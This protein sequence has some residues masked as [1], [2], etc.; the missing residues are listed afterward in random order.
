MPNKISSSASETAAAPIT[1]ATVLYGLI[2]HPAHHSLSPLIHNRGFLERQISARYLA[3]D[4]QATAADI[5]TSIKALNIRGLNLS[6]P[7]KETMLPLMDELTPTAKLIGAI[8]TIKN[9]TGH[10]LGTNTDG[11]GLVAAIQATGVSIKKQHVL[12]LGGGATARAILVALVQAGCDHVTVVQRPESR[13][14]Q[15]MQQLLSALA[16]ADQTCQPWPQ[17][18][19]LPIE[20]YSLVINAT[21]IGFGDQQDQSPLSAEW[22]SQLPSTC[23]VWD[24]IYQPRQSNLLT[25][26][27]QQGLATHNGLA[28]L[29][30]QAA[31]SFEFWT[32]K[33]LPVVSI[34]QIIKQ[35]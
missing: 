3:F 27:E 26:A 14:Y 2:A 23:Q 35:K 8:N 22:L 15:Q 17:L 25:L 33:T 7:Y 13:H 28:M 1:G 6:L 4:T 18:A 5:A 29:C 30:Y 21:S 31:A 12:L 24:V 32:G 11:Q 34:Y 19:N 20:D 10:L 9:E 16:L